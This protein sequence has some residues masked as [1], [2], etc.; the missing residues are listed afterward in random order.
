MLSLDQMRKLRDAYN[1]HQPMPEADAFEAIGNPTR[2]AVVETALE[3][4]KSEDRNVRVLMLRVLSGQ[5]GDKA[6]HGILTGLNDQ[7]RRVKEVAIKSCRSFLHYPEITE[8]LEA[9]VIDEKEHKKIRSG[10]LFCL[11][12]HGV[13]ATLQVLPK[14][15]AD[16]LETL[17][18]NEQ[19]R[20]EI[21]FRLLMLDLSEHVEALLRAFVKHGSKEEAVMATRALCGYRVIHIGAFENDKAMLRHVT[22]TY[23]LAAGRV[24]YWMKRS[25]FEALT[26][27]STQPSKD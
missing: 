8:K 6:M 19:L 20:G 3:G 7:K 15:A 13:G 26:Q 9:L 16:A 14:A 4:L 22:Q 27:A 17:S 23:E 18:Q 10:A 25:E 24:F 11:T 2:E 21:L 5:S 12:G 1:P